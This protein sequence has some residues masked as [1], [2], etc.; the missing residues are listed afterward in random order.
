MLSLT[1]PDGSREIRHIPVDWARAG[2]Y[3]EIELE[4]VADCAYTD[5]VV[6]ASLDWCE[7]DIGG[8]L[9]SIGTTR[10]TAVSLGSFTA[11]QRK[12]ITIRVTIPS[13]ASTRRTLIDLIIGLGT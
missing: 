12:D 2:Q 7:I 8:G 3:Y 1:A 6:W 11:G 13:P 5:V 9:T 10:A 4:A